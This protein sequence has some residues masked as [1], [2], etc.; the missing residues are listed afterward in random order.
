MLTTGSQAQYSFSGG[1]VTAFY[2]YDEINRS[3]ADEYGTYLY[4]GTKKTVELYANYAIG[5]HVQ[6]LG[7]I[8]Y[9]KQKMND[10]TATPAN[11]TAELTSPYLS[12]FLRD[13]GGFNLELGGR[14]NK[15]SKY[16]ENFTYSINPSIPSANQ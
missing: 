10:A 12:F 4:A 1:S 15:H 11:P 16:G 9:N 13:M 6:L 7:G 3:F 8:H 2:D 14:Y 5:N